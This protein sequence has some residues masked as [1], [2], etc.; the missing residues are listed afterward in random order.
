MVI[1]RKELLDRAGDNIGA[2]LKYKTHAD[3]DSLYNTPPVFPIWAMSRVI[4]WIE[5]KGGLEGIQK[6]NAEKANLLYGVIDG[7]DG[8]YH[9]PVDPA[10]R[11]TMNVVFTMKNDELQA[12]FLKGAAERDMLGLKGH[13]AVGGCRAS[14]Y[15]AMPLEGVQ[16]L[17]DYMRD[18]AE[19]NA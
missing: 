9:C 15:N 13:R 14:I 19:K 2:Y 7:T 17:A 5:G 6:I 18:F 11:S 1:I 12:A 4:K 8:F 3:K 16:A 10:V